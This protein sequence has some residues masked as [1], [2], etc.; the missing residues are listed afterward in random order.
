MRDHSAATTVFPSRPLKAGGE[1][2]RRLTRAWGP[3]SRVLASLIPGGSRLL[4][5]RSA[6]DIDVSLPDRVR[7]SFPTDFLSQNS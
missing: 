6:R 2:P 4:T 3:R 5:G 1:A 7:T